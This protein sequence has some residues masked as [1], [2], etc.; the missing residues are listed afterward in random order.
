MSVLSAS[1]TSGGLQSFVEDASS[2]H[3]DE[4]RDVLLDEV[5][6]IRDWGTETA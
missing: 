6:G 2:R 4:R 1:V 5:T 3:P